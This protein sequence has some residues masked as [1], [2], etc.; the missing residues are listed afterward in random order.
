MAICSCRWALALKPGSEKVMLAGNWI[1]Q[2]PLLMTN[3]LK[4]R[5]R[6]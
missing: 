3:I 5:A 4:D 2:W 6:V 1:A